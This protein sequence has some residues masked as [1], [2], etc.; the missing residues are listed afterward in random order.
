MAGSFTGRA[1]QPV[2]VEQVRAFVELAR[3]G[4]IRLA[5]RELHLSEEG[6]RGRLLALEE[7]LG[8]D[9]YEKERGRRSAVRLTHAGQSF[10][11]KAIPFLEDARRLTLVFEPGASRQE[12]K[13]A[14][15]HYVTSYLLADILRSFHR[16][17]PD[18][19]VGVS[20][21]TE[22]QVITVLQ[23]DANFSVGICA[24]E[25]FPPCLKYQPWLPMDWHFVA[26]K[27]HPLLQRTSVALAD[28]A[29]EPL[30]M[31][32]P[33]STGRQHLLEAFSRRELVPRIVTD[34]TTTA[35]ALRLIEAGIGTAIL[36]LLRSGAVTRE[37]HVG[38]VPIQDAIRGVENAIVFRPALQDN[39]LVRRL[40]DLV[41]RPLTD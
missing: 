8:V 1:V 26:P 14:A 24:P 17:F 31:L 16:Q 29:T 13:I 35:I 10:L 2:S 21:C 20:T 19:V 30:I 12:L 6:M 33:G 25:E 15:S 11:E 7:R 40:L 23:N 22:R 28:I 39:L 36:P 5:A 41:Q 38:Q 27:G 4:N 32:E 9:L 3:A 37:A 34:V 18:V